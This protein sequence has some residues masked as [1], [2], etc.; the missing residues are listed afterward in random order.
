MDTT[1]EKYKVTLPPLSGNLRAPQFRIGWQ[2]REQ[3]TGEK[4]QV[5][6]GEHSKKGKE[7]RVDSLTTVKNWMSG[8]K[9]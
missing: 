4:N 6:N 8:S 9:V 1:L 7:N 5:V 2:D 3:A